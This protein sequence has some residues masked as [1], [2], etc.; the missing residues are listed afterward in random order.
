[1][2]VLYRFYCFIR[3]YAAKECNDL[4]LRKRV[5]TYFILETGTDM[6]GHMKYHNYGNT[7]ERYQDDTKTSK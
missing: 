6:Q 3:V 2:A 4:I 5:F 7:S 1:M